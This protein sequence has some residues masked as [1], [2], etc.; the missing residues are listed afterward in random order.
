MTLPSLVE[1]GDPPKSTHAM[2]MPPPPVC[3][4]GDKV[5]H[6]HLQSVWLQEVVGSGMTKDLVT[7]LVKA[8][9]KVPG[10]R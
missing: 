2:H 3:C 7:A 5:A 8:Y 10:G 4:L 1:A 6:A 9:L